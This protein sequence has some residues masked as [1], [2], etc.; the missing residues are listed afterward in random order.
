MIYT[1]RYQHV[2][3]INVTKNHTSSFYRFEEHTFYYGTSMP[4]F[5]TL[6]RDFA[7][8]SCL[9]AILRKDP[10]LLDP[11]KLLKEYTMRFERDLT[12]SSLLTPSWGVSGNGKLTDWD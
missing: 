10:T 8:D 11:L 5:N 1:N 9:A 2:P 4:I 6:T 12:S 3:F 7:A